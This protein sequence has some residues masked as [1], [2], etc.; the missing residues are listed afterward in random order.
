[1]VV[2]LRA[3]VRRERR[4]A[5]GEVLGGLALHLP[6]LGRGRQRDRTRR[7]RRRR[8]RRQRVAAVS[9]RLGGPIGQD[10]LD[11]AQRQRDIGLLGMSIGRA[12]KTRERQGDKE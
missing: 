7:R 9:H 2:V 12:Q 10:R 5:A 4:A 6:L 3:D 11:G 1:A 8:R